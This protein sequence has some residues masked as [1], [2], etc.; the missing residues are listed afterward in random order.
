MLRC[1][2]DR[3]NIHYFILNYSDIKNLGFKD[4]RGKIGLRVIGGCPTHIPHL[5]DLTD[6]RT[7]GVGKNDDSLSSFEKS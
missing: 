7:D 3:A 5:P 4:L 1:R 2:F 6:G